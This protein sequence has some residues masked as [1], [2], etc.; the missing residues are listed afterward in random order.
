[1]SQAP[2]TP[3]IPTPRPPPRTLALCPTG[4]LQGEVVFGAEMSTWA[5]PGPAGPWYSEAQ[6]S[7]RA[8]AVVADTV[9][10]NTPSPALGAVQFIHFNNATYAFGGVGGECGLSRVPLASG[11]VQRPLALPTQDG[12]C[13]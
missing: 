1:M 7:G 13:A 2:R 3:R 12:C 6:L 5:S 9:L 8:P 10:P 4:V 11:R